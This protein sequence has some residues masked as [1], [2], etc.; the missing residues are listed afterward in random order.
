MLEVLPIIDW[1][2][3]GVITVSALI[4]LVRGFVREALSLGTLIAAVVV[5][6]VFGG[7]V[8]TL[9]VDYLSEPSMRL[10]A[11]YALLFVSTMIVGGMVNHLIASLVDATGL[12]GTD[13]FLGAI[14]GVARG[15]VIIVVA[16]AILARMP[17]TEDSWW[18]E[19]KL[20]PSFL[21]AA[22]S[23]QDMVFS[24]LSEGEQAT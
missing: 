23:I 15:A 4:S 1:I 13:R 7:Q 17:V 6:R 18:K 21:A 11:A 16:V 5:A 19:S 24:S 22:N 8:A 10:L 14:F 9:F 20:I 3:I 12:S 2:I